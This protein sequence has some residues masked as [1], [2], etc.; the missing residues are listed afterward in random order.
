MT[1]IYFALSLLALITCGTFALGRRL[2]Q[3]YSPAVCNLIAAIT[4]ATILFYICNVWDDV[5]LARLLPFSN[6]IILGNWF[7]PASGFL[8]GLMWQNLSSQPA[9]SRIL[10]VMLVA[11]GAYTAIQPL[12]GDQPQCHSRWAGEVCLQTSPYTCGPASAATLLRAHGIDAT[13]QEMAGLC[14]TRSGLVKDGTSWQGLYR[15][16]KHKTRGTG[17]EVEV[18]RCSLGELPQMADR[19]LLLSV[20]L[21]DDPSLDP[22]YREEL[23]WIPGQFHTVVLFEFLPRA[24]VQM[25]DP[26]VG[27]EVWP[28]SDLLHLWQGQGI[29]LVPRRF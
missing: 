10:A 2:G 22:V 28:T 13:E 26:A 21:P 27:P 18:F 6:L 7:P 20:G 23:G 9:R 8:A 5:L 4:F 29:R 16:L 12:Y 14:L 1:D 24:R 15:G 25:G 19:P 17:W 3:R 11:V